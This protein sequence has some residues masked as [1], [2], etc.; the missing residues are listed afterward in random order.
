MARVSLSALM[1]TIVVLAGAL[2]FGVPSGDKDQPRFVDKKEV[3]VANRPKVPGKLLLHLRERR[4]EPEGS[5]KI[6]VT[7]R[8]TEWEVSET[9]IIICDMWDDHHCKLAAQRVGLMAPRM[10]EVLTAARD[11]GVMIIHAPSETMNIYA[12][13]SYRSRMEQAKPAKAP[14]P[15]GTRCDRNPSSEPQTLPED[16]E[17]DCDDPELGPVVRRHTRQNR[18][19]REILVPVHS[20]RGSDD[21]NR[22]LGRTEVN[23]RFSGGLADARRTC[24][25]KAMHLS[26]QQ[27]RLCSIGS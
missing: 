17:L 19:Y 10:N 6:E 11:R 26:K 22:R 25:G 8:T 15:I 7:E 16:T 24:L 4:E 23:V 13:T 1:L 18:R 5:G 3:R 9:A 2:V 20:G 14:V 12:G 21:G 27:P